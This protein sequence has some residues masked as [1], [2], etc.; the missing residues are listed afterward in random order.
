MD[1][2]DTTNPSRMTG[3]LPMIS[4]NLFIWRL[5]TIMERLDKEN[6]AVRVIDGLE[7]LE[8]LTNNPT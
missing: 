7:Q 4:D 8:A 2:T 1:T 3:F 5:A 6:C